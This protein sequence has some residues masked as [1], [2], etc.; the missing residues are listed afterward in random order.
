[1]CYDEDCKDFKSADMKLP[2][3]C[4]PWLQLFEDF[5]EELTAGYHQSIIDSDNQDSNDSLLLKAL[6]DAEEN[7]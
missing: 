6:E 3:N 1:M 7:L 2:E 4:Q 5:D